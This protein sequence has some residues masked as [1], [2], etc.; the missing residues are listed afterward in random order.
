MN[1]EV[2]QKWLTALSSGKY[3][4]VNG[5]LRDKTGFCCLGVLC[6][7][8]AEE[9]PD[10]EGWGK[11]SSTGYT[12]FI[13]ENGDFDDLALPTGVRKWAGLTDDDPNI[14]GIVRRKGNTITESRATTLARA[15]DSGYT[16]H[17]IAQII[18]REL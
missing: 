3:E 13:D 7:L 14:K 18:R 4:Q 5:R 17:E 1:V 11:T 10:A 6:D 15:N 8:Y 2:K 16:F 9:H 12:Q